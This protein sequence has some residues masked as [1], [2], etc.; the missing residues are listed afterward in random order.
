MSYPADGKPRYI[1]AETA[2]QG[3][4]NH[5]TPHLDVAVLD[6][7]YCHVE[8]WWET[9]MGESMRVRRQ[10]GDAGLLEALRNRAHGVAAMMEA[11]ARDM[12]GQ[13]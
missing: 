2:W 7:A 9:T 4:T 3:G 6:R 8:V 13:Q 10:L 1:V 12:N 5:K 11:E